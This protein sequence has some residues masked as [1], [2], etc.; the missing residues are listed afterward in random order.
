MVSGTLLSTFILILV[1][2]L[3]CWLAWWLIG[4]IGLPQ[5]FD[6]ALRILVAIVAFIFLANLLLGLTGHPL[7]DGGAFTVHR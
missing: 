4:F 2:G 6:K 1:V 7:F 3:L 5:P